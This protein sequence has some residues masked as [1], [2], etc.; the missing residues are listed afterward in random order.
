M[1]VTRTTD[2]ADEPVTVD[3]LMQH[4]RI[5]STAD[6]AWLA[7]AIKAAR[8]RVEKEIGRSLITQTW[9]AYLDRFPCGDVRLPYPPTI[10]ISSVKYYDGNNELQTLSASVYQIDTASEPARFK[11]A[12]GK[13]WPSTYCRLNAVEI[14]YTAGYGADGE[15]VPAAIRHAIMMIVGHLYE[16]RETVNDFQLHD[17]PMGAGWL[18]DSYRVISF[19]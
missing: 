3:E 12:Y 14:A 18:L 19:E 15:S 13:S 6:N 9:T 4:S 2:A 10:A 1:R 11:V 17:I 5:Q 7:L 16:H 8:Q